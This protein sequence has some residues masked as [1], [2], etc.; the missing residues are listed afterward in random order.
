MNRRDSLKA[1]GFL[2]AGTGILTKSCSQEKQ[3]NSSNATKNLN[4]KLPGIQD[5]E[6]ERN[7]NL[8]EEQFFSEHEMATIAILADYIIPK[9]DFSGSASEAG[10]PDFI[11]FMVKDMPEYKT[12]M[13]GGLKWIDIRCQK[14]FGQAFKNCKENQQVALLDEIAFPSKNNPE[15]EQGVNFF[16]TLRNL[17]ASG[18]YTSKIGIDDLGY[19]GNKPGVWTGVPEDVL[20]EHGFSTNEG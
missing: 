16:K 14:K 17:T 13:R 20:K 8:Y 10:V 11:E 3:S 15:V 2:A 5:F 9:D 4:D 18:F 1:L 7:L 12:P 19:V 6:H